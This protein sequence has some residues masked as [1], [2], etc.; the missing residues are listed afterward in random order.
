M[1]RMFSRYLPVIVGV[2]TLLAASAATWWLADFV[3]QREKAQQQAGAIQVLATIRAQLEGELNT[4]MYATHGLS[5]LI[6]SDPDV[7]DERLQRMA[8]ALLNQTPH[9]SHF[10][11]APDNVVR[12]VHPLEGNEA[13]LGLDFAAQPDQRAA[14]ERAVERRQLI[15][16]GPVELV[17]G[18]TALAT[19]EPV[20]LQRNGETSYWGLVT[21]VIQ[22]E[23]LFAAAGL[24]DEDLG[25]E[26]ALRSLDDDALL[27]GNAAL[28]DKAELRQQVQLKG[29][30]WELA[31]RSLPASTPGMQ[32]Y[33]LGLGLALSLAG[34]LGAWRLSG[35]GLALRRSEEK[36]RTLV[37]Q[38]NDG[39]C[40]AQD[41]VLRYVN[42]RLCEL[43]ERNKTEL[44]GRAFDTLIAEEYREE[45]V[46]RHQARMRGERFGAT[47]ELQIIRPDGGLLDARINSNQVDWHGRPAALVTVTDISEQKALHQALRD[48]R[49]RLQALIRAMPD[50]GFII[51]EHGYY[52]DVIGGNSAHYSSS[53]GLIGTRLVDALPAE[54]AE[55]FMRL[56]RA[57]LD[58][59]TM[60]T[61]EYSLNVEDVKS[62]PDTPPFGSQWF[63]AR[64]VP[65]HAFGSEHPA[66][67][68]LAFNITVRKQMEASLRQREAA[69]QALV[70][71]SPDVIA[72]LDRDLRVVYMNSV[73]E[74]YTGIPAQALT[75][76][77]RPEIAQDAE[78][79]S[80]L[81]QRLQQVFEDG[82]MHMFDFRVRAPDGQ[83]LF[84]ECRAIPEPGADGNINSILVLER[85]ITRRKRSEQQLRLAASV[86]QHTSEAMLVSDAHRRVVRCNPAY[87]ELTGYEPSDLIG[88][89]SPL[90]TS[91]Q[92]EGQLDEE[93]W[94]ELQERGR[95]Q[96]EMLARRRDGDPF[97]AWITVTTIRDEGGTISH[98]LVTLADISNRK[99]REEQLRHDAT[100]DPLTGLP[101][102]TLLMDRLAIAIAQARRNEQELAVLFI[103]LDGFKPVNDEL[104][105]RVGDVVLQELA[106]RLQAKVR[107]TDTVA[108]LGGDEFVVVLTPPVDQQAAD[109]VAADILKQLPQ[110][111]MVNGRTCSV[112]AS[113]GISRFPADGHDPDTLIMAADAAMYQAKTQGGRTFTAASGSS[114]ASAN[115]DRAY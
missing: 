52:L 25:L 17:Q 46:R 87:S 85:E 10:A 42:P 28:F 94:K 33:W 27:M 98:Y 64:V 88:R 31:A 61:L 37:E 71:N 30:T 3:N 93:A 35:Q 4:T 58:S 81:E 7:P 97:P 66:V 38:L 73:A 36:Y 56:I 104:G 26:L 40:I 69:F 103:D 11:I 106:Q 105:H 109:A 86:F 13:A 101:N 32:P 39:V 76:R 5:A 23:S 22:M 77:R 47:Y 45:L 95:W 67:L 53:E 75:G 49:D 2:V 24:L 63:E 29:A 89:P 74:R 12:F 9:T 108:R 57:T 65:L 82:R 111:V 96:G 112:G 51:D 41:G 59:N 84:F 6:A 70:E 18:G 55:R 21:A 43:A 107:E 48:S 78:L 16:T 91:T 15:I 54:E 113:I 34:G 72:R 8:Q 102:R 14:V 80:E 60:Q 100:H 90:L 50:I 110:P 115:R 92:M 114:V 44:I 79:G 19:R 68:W 20:F 62:T 83:L 99:R 1:P